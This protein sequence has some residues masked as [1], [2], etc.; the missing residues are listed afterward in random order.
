MG[1]R[2]AKWMLSASVVDGAGVH[3]GKKLLFVAII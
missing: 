3:G 2:K 1:I